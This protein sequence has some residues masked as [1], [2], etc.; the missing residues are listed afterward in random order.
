VARS[1]QSNSLGTFDFNAQSS[2][3][4]ALVLELAHG[5]WIEQRQNCIAP[6]PFG[7]SKTTSAWHQCPAPKLVALCGG[8][9]GQAGR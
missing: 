9:K 5:E 1:P 6:G 4:K 8:R 3:N 7:A 2:L